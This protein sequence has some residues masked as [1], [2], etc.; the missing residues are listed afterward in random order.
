MHLLIIDKEN[1]PELKR[2]ALTMSI[3]FPVIFMAILP[4]I[5]GFGIPLWPG[6][7][8]AVLLIMYVIA[9]KFLHYPQL[10]WAWVSFVL[11]WVNT[12]ILLWIVFYVLIFP[13]G[14]IARLAGKLNYN[15]HNG[16]HDKVLK[17]SFWIK[18]ESK[19]AKHELENPF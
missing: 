5:F 10:A 7:L 4:W 1:I 2:F 11:G 17:N 15:N 13:V 8:S 16:S 14:F 6:F 19:A 9:P 18:R 12:R 3:A